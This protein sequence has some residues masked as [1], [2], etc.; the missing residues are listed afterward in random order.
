MAVGGACGNSLLASLYPQSPSP[1]QGGCSV[2]KAVEFYLDS[3]SPYA[4]LANAQLAA[5]SLDVVCKPISIL[6]AMKV[7]GNTS[8]P[9]CP[10]KLEHAMADTARFAERDAVPPRSSTEFRA[11]LNNGT[12][13][14][15]FSA[16]AALAAQTLEQFVGFH[17]SAF[18]A[19]WAH[20]QSIAASASFEALPD[21]AGLDGNAITALAADP[22]T[23]A[24]LGRANAEVVS[25]GVFGVPFFQVGDRLDF[26]KAAAVGEAN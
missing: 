21:S 23:E 24:A 5:L 4:Y 12:V 10:P 16:C 7:V 18:D 20:S 22:G 3:V 8:S 2:S 14:P 17:A 19:F 25:A 26:V 1:P 9:V 13:N 11:G 15:G 6:D